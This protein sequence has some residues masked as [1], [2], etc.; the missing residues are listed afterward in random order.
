MY[1]DDAVSIKGC[2]TSHLSWE[3]ITKVTPGVLPQQNLS[4]SK[5]FNLKHHIIQSRWH[6]PTSNVELCVLF[7]A[8]NLKYSLCLIGGYITVLWC[9]KSW[10]ISNRVKLQQYGTWWSGTLGGSGGLTAASD[11]Q[12]I[13]ADCGARNRVSS[14]PSHM[15]SV[16]HFLVFH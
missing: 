4:N 11:L 5:L 8:F 12:R 6:S 15:I 3:D 9:W 16:C 14:L 2:R 10:I 13:R 1:M 7:N